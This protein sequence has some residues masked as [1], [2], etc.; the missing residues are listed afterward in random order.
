MLPAAAEY[1]LFLT[2]IILMLPIAAFLPNFIAVVLH[3]RI[4]DHFHAEVSKGDPLQG[5]AVVRPGKIDQII[6]G[7]KAN[8]G[9]GARREQSYPNTEHK[10][11]L[12]YLRLLFFCLSGWIVAPNTFVLLLILLATLFLPPTSSF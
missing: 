12:H 9:R 7:R 2:P 5:M 6:I 3:V 10:A 8:L 1:M 4:V 11:T